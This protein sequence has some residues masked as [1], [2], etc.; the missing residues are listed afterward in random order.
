MLTHSL[1]P[2]ASKPVTHTSIARYLTSIE[3][4]KHLRLSERTLSYLRAQSGGPP[5]IAISRRRIVYDVAEL[6]RWARSRQFNSISE[7]AA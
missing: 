4:A 2:S 7:Y 1:P 5:F 3:A 6:D